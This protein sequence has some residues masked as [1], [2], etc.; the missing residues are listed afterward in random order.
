V[1][2]EVPDDARAR[3]GYPPEVIHRVVR[4]GPGGRLTTKG[5][6]RKTPDP[7]TVRATAIRGE[8]VATI[9]AAGRVL[10]FL[11]STLGLIWLAGGALVLLVLP[12]LDRRREARDDEMD[13]AVAL[14]EAL[15]TITQEL[16]E[17]RG[18]ASDRAVAESG[19]LD[20]L[21]AEARE[22]RAQLA[23]IQELVALQPAPPEPEPAP[24][25]AAPA[26]RSGGLVGAMEALYSRRS[27]RSRH[28]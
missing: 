25:T 16:T 5:D 6:A 28:G 26:R 17:L 14:D 2:V 7:F 3:Y 10:G 15:A 20:A 8:V 11:T 19:A 9:P 1:A 13:R 22:A 18:Q 27:R 24:P 12:R 21:R 23:A 4:I